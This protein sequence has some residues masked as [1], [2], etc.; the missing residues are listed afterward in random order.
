M[1]SWFFSLRFR[2]VAGFALVLALALASVSL[3]VSQV[4]RAE[5]EAFE[6][7]HSSRVGEVRLNPHRR[8]L[9]WRPQNPERH[10]YRDRVG[11]LGA[12]GVVAV[13]PRIEDEPGGE[14]GAHD[15]KLGADI[16]RSRA[17]VSDHEIEYPSG[18]GN[19]T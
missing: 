13:G 5:T 7:I 17:E 6:R 16:S 18:R 4:A 14:V 2:L 1:P 3:Y 11:E 12:Q 19:S 9:Q 15:G 8:L 10:G